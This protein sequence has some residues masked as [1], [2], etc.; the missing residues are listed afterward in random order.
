MPLKDKENFFQDD[1]DKGVSSGHKKMATDDGLNDTR[2]K[3]RVPGREALVE[4]TSRGTSTL[5]SME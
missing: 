1:E 4:N 3:V 2:K 5:A